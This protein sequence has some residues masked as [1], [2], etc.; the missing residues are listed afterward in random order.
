MF[1]RN[2]KNSIISENADINIAVDESLHE[3]WNNPKK[4]NVANELLKGHIILKGAEFFLEAL[5]KH[6]VG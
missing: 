3:M 2:I 4:L 5:K 1:E 6:N